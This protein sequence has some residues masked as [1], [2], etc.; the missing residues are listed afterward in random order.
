MLHEP[1]AAR[2]LGK[3]YALFP[4]PR[5]G[6][7]AEIYKTS[8]LKADGQIVAVKIFRP[9]VLNERLAREAFHRETE[10]IRSCVHPN[11][12]S[13]LDAGTD[14]ETGREFLVLEWI[15]QNL[16]QFREKQGFRDWDEFYELIG[17]PILD[18]LT[19]A[20]GRQ[21]V[22]RDVKPSNILF[23]EP[24]VPKLADFNI[25]KFRRWRE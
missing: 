6:G 11:I 3:R 21:I 12:V 23:D 5:Q 25:A 1:S 17:R 16:D 22:H 13:L 7:M 10:A 18:A 8:D 19:L 14:S 20:H 4:N 9:E 24:S 2:L 15:A